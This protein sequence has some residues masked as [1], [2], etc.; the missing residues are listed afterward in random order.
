MQ[1]PLTQYEY[2]SIVKRIRADHVR[3]AVEELLA[4]ARAR[5][6]ELAESTGPRTF[7][8]TLGALERFTEK[9]DY[10][11]RV[12]GHLESVSTYPE[13]RAAY[14]A[15]QPEVSE[16]YTNIVLD[17]GLWRVLKE[18][19][20]T[21][22]A[23]SLTGTKKRLLTKT[24]DS[25]RRHGAE[26]DEAGKR[27]LGIID[28]EL[29]QATT[30]FSENVLDSTNAFEYLVTEESRL[31]G[32]PES[33]RA[34]ARENAKAK[35]LEGWR[36]TLQAPSYTPVMTYLDDADVRQH[37]YH[38][39]VTRATEG[40]HDN[41]TLLARI[42]ELRRQKANLIGYAHFAALVLEDRMAHTGTKALH[43]LGELLPKTKPRFDQENRE[44][45]QFRRD[46]EG[47]QAPALQPWD[48]GYY[49]EKQRSKLYDFDE[50]ALRP[51]FPLDRVVAGL[52]D[53][54][55]KLF[56]IRVEEQTAGPLC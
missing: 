37:F 18:Y 19:A 42:L 21:E 53:I 7:D 30:K 46:L 10:A 16:F 43:F 17:A 4:E 50:E 31:A 3:T 47:P 56:G 12:V 52:F 39:F 24:M 32:L 35:G 6:K 45:Q 36:F 41:R 8:N 44:L 5:Q 22:E 1:N 38:A 26:L 40:S 2:I 33:A 48:V 29:T 23:H 11:M 28:V 13:W 34:A 15:V 51:Y 54:V 25:F 9:L 55:Q 14:N 20:A 27:K 49:A